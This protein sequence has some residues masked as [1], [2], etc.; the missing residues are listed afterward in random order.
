MPDFP[1]IELQGKKGKGKGASELQG[2]VMR[3][4]LTR[5]LSPYFSSKG[6]QA[7]GSHNALACIEQAGRTMMCPTG[8]QDACNVFG[9]KAGT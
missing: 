9:R 2:W 8:G 4:P 6:P 1:S 3:L 5:V 7:K